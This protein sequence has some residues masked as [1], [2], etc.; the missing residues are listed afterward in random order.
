MNILAIDIGTTTGWA[1][2]QSA[3]CQITSGRERFQVDRFSG[4]GMRYVRFSAWLRE[5]VS[6]M[7]IQ[8]VTY[9][10]VRRH[11]STDAAH[12]YGGFMSHL[13]AF[14][15]SHEPAKLPYCSYPVATIKKHATG[16][17]NAKKD[18]MLDAARMRFAD[19][20]I[21]DDNQA[22][23]LWILDLAVKQFGGIEPAKGG[24]P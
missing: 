2:Y 15:D 11:M 18:A 8:M 16:K 22:D 20:A 7:Q 12:C 9:E 19:Q 13:T 4:G 5:I 10:E 1:T 3:S 21:A 14:C 23:A 6:S 24:Q 17:G